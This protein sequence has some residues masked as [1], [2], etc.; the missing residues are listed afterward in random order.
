MAPLAEIFMTRRSILMLALLAF[1]GCNAGPTEPG[2]EGPLSLSQTSLTL[3]R[4]ATGSVTATVGPAGRTSDVTADATWSSSNPS[5][6]V[7][8]AG[9]LRAVGLGSATVTASYRGRTATMQVAVRRNTA[10]GGHI[11]VR[12]TS[13]K[14]V[15]G[16]LSVRKSGE[17]IGSRCG[18]DHYA[19]VWQSADFGRATNVPSIHARSEVA[20]GTVDLEVRVSF[21]EQFASGVGARLLA[22]DAASYIEIFDA[23]TGA[24]LE[25]SP[26]PRHEA[27]LA[28]GD[29]FTLSIAVKTYLQ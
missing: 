16:C 27:V 4:N 9:Q 7:A 18:S 28:T 2:S 21:Q 1:S 22:S 23:D 25:R 17:S 12:E 11:V 29:V 14:E 3:G 8:E 15:F 5:I 19:S 26:L 24:S 13:G 6:V 10:L 20:P